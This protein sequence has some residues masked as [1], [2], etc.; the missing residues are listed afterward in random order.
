MPRRVLAVSIMERTAIELDLRAR[1]A[2]PDE[3]GNKIQSSTAPDSSL[4]SQT[5]NHAIHERGI[6]NCRGF[7]RSE[8]SR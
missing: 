4:R 1:E 2:E 3:A 7:G 8:R 6:E 5:L